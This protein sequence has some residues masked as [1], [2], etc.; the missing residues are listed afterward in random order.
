MMASRREIHVARRP[1]ATMSVDLL[2]VMT[3]YPSM[4]A[5]L[6]MEP[7]LTLRDTESLISQLGREQIVLS[8]PVR[9]A[10]MTGSERP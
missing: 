6:M 2:A 8:G 1:L 9:Q 7:I 5:G 10:R 4:A 3:A